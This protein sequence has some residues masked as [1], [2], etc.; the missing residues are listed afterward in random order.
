MKNQKVIKTVKQYLLT[1]IILIFSQNISYSQVETGSFEFDG[2]TRGY[3]VFL[4]QNYQSYMPVVFNFHGLGGVNQIH[5][6]HTGM[7]NHA[8][9]SDFI[10]VYPQGINNNWNFGS[11]IHP[12]YIDDIGFISALIDTLDAHYNIDMAR[13][14]CSGFSIGAGMTNRLAAELTHRIAAVAPIAGN[15]ID[16]ALTWNP[17]RP[18][19]VL[20]M[21][22]TADWILNYNG[23]SN[24][25]SVEDSY[26][27][28]IQNSNCSLLADT[29]LLPNLDTT[30]NSTVEKI[31]WTDCSNNSSVVHYKIIN[32]EHTWPGSALNQVGAITNRDINANVEIWNFFKNYENPL[33]DM[34]W[35]KT[36]EVFPGYLDPQGDTLFVKAYITN[37]ENHPVSVSAKIDG[38]EVSFSDSLLLYDD[39]NHFDVNPNDNIWG[40][41]KVLSGLAA[42]TYAVE[43]NTHDITENVIHKHHLLKYFTNIGPVVVED[44]EITEQGTNVF[45][46]IYSLKNADSTSV[47]TGGL[48]AELS[49]LD[50]NVTYISEDLTN[51]VILF[52]GQVSNPSDPITIKIQNNPKSIDFIVRI[53]NK[54]HLLWTDSI[55]VTGIIGIE[56]N[57]TNLSLEQTLKQNYPNP[58]NPS[59][60][61]QYSLQVA[62]NVNLKI[63]NSLGQ[64]VETLVDEHQQ[65][66]S[67]DVTFNAN[68]LQSG[69]YYCI[70][71]TNPASQNFGTAQTIKMI[72]ME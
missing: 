70:L 66:G 35:S 34:A 23:A 6:N 55:T 19:P 61:I 59:T 30:D 7:N 39:G 41:A 57:G 40:N 25:W 28:W 1:F 44:F 36:V 52:P 69:I 12:V 15:M 17:I 60:V 68:S 24:Y 33:V 9:T 62:S 32:G 42:D 54:H 16:I 47:I 45:K 5:M 51:Y 53:F 26:N 67:F 49:T 50:T 11:V 65:A 38:T 8:D 56:E 48:F 58:F 71:K 27:F 63:Y 37:P 2:H 29:I 72:K 20:D 21:H 10:V 46:L 31:S 22:G 64:E 18:I 4:P 13:I 3:A 14:Y 43:I